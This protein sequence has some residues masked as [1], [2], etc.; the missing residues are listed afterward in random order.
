ML[1]GSGTAKTRFSDLSSTASE[2]VPPCN[3]FST[4]NAAE[5]IVR[6]VSTFEEIVDVACSNVH[7]RLVKALKSDNAPPT[8]TSEI[9]KGL[10]VV[11]VTAKLP[12]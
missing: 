4:E 11:A 6:F 10:F 8:L 3:G 2:K 7:E 5:S 9:T 12:A 1:D